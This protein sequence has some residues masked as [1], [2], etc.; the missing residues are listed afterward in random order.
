MA[1][2]TSAPGRTTRRI[3]SSWVVAVEALDRRSSPVGLYGRTSPGGHGGG[4]SGTS[5]L[6]VGYVPAGAGG[7]SGATATVPGAGGA[8]SGGGQGL[9]DGCGVWGP[10]W[11]VAGGAGA[12][13][14]GGTGGYLR[15]GWGGRRCDQYAGWGGGG[16]GG[17]YGGGGG[18]G[19]VTGGAGGGGGSGYGPAG[20]AYVL[21][22]SGAHGVI[23]VSYHVWV[24]L[25]GGPMTSAPTIATRG[26][27]GLP[28]PAHDL[29]Y[30]GANS[31]V[32]Q[33]IVTGGVPGPEY[34]LGGVLYPG[35]TVAALW[36]QH[37]QRLDLFARGTRSEL[38]QLSFT[39]SAG[40]GT[41]RTVAGVGSLT[42]D[43]AVTSMQPDSLDVFF[44]GA[45]NDL[46]HL[47][48]LD[49]RAQE[50]ASLGGDLVTGPA[51]VTLDGATRVV[52]GENQ[53]LFERGVWVE[54]VWYD[55]KPGWSRLV[56]GSANR[57][58]SAVP[59]LYSPAAGRLD[60]ALR[61]TS[62]GLAWTRRAGS[63]FET[64]N[65]PSPAG[66]APALIT[67]PE[68]EGVVYLRGHHDRLMALGL[69]PR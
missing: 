34:V 52:S 49:G 6:P 2:P 67:T 31:Q 42:S 25:G 41:W 5:A 39:W 65:A 62:S 3:A 11:P 55:A 7:G 22:E 40:W 43:P 58:L 60:I 26:P 21:G 14:A 19:G 54:R 44:R 18:G 12:G 45:G 29:F 57:V 47:R 20:S 38:W 30:L 17:W 36:S 56:N 53:Q 33:R 37:G 8:P 28:V 10:G 50:P 63:T 48:L 46:Q 9:P 69:G 13:A 1:R 32:V 64:T 35:S 68:G 51:V 23:S 15:S 24:D 59:S 66:S 27:A 16:G 61:N 4:A